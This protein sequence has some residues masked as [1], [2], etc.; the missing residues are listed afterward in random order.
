MKRAA[1]RQLE[2]NIEY[3]QQSKD[4]CRWKTHNSESDSFQ[5]NMIDLVVILNEVVLGVITQTFWLP[6]QK[7][8]QKK[9]HKKPEWSKYMKELPPFFCCLTWTFAGVIL[10]QDTPCPL[11][12]V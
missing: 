4:F 10:T 8:T 6:L 3:H 5:N 7:E 9:I 12:S 2:S 11:N 1:K